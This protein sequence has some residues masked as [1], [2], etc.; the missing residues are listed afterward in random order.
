MRVGGKG[1]NGDK[2]LLGVVRVTT[3]L[4]IYRMMSK[5]MQVPSLKILT[6]WAYLGL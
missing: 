1:K 4:S 3:H 5:V 6:V 2:P